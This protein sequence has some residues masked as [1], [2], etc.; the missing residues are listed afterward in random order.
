[1]LTARPCRE[2]PAGGIQAGCWLAAGGGPAK[3]S[4]IR[5]LGDFAGLVNG[6]VGNESDYFSVGAD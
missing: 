6:A 3:V 2:E 4:N 5:R 1:M